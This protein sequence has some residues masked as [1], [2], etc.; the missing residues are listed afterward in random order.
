MHLSCTLVFYLCN[1]LIVQNMYVSLNY[2]PECKSIFSISLLVFYYV[3]LILL[4]AVGQD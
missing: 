1:I 4:A 3:Q 2:H